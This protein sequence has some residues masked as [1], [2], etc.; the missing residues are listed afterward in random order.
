MALSI[1]AM[2][3]KMHRLR[4]EIEDEVVGQA[5]LDLK[6]IFNSAEEKLAL[7]ESAFKTLLTKGDQLQNIPA[8]VD[9]ASAIVNDLMGEVDEYL[10]GPGQQ[11]ADDIIPKM[12]KAGRDL[13][14][15]NL[16]VKF[17]DSDQLKSTFDLVSMSEKAVLK[18][19]Y[20]DTYKI[21]NVVGDDVTEWFRQTMMDSIFEELPIVNKLDPRAD[22]LMSRL[23]ESG[24]IKPLVIK[25]KSGKMIT[26]SIQQRAE[27]IARVESSKIINRT[28]ETKAAE[29]L[30]DEAVYRNSNPHDSR[31]TPICRR[32]SE[33][34]PMTLVEWS[35]SDLGRPPRLSPFHLCRS[36]LIGGR[37]EWF[38]DVPE[39][40][41]EAQTPLPKTK[42][43]PKAAIASRKALK[44]K[45]A[46]KA[47]AEA[48]KAQE[49]AQALE[50]AKLQEAKISLTAP[51]AIQFAE[52]LKKIENYGAQGRAVRFDGDAVED[53]TFHMYNDYLDPSMSDDLLGPEKIRSFASLKIAEESEQKIVDW[54]KKETRFSWGAGSARPTSKVQDIQVPIRKTLKGG[55]LKASGEY[56]TPGDFYNDPE[57]EGKE[58]EI[59][60]SDGMKIRYRPADLDGVKTP[61]SYRGS[62][63]I[64][65]N[66]PWTQNLADDI[67]KR[68]EDMDIPARL[69]TSADIE[70]A[71]LK[72]MA[73]NATGQEVEMEI[74]DQR[75]LVNVSDT[76]HN[77]LLDKIKGWPVPDQVLELRQF[78]GRR[79]DVDD[80]TTLRAY[81]PEGE[82]DIS[83]SSWVDS[84]GIETAG[85]RHQYRFDIDDNDIPK[86]FNLYHSVA[87]LKES[88][89]KEIIDFFQKG[90]LENSARV[91][92][93]R[94]KIRR[95]IKRS[96]AES[97]AED[98]AGWG[99]SYAYLRSRPSIAPTWGGLY[100]KRRNYRR[101]DARHFK[102]DK[103]GAVP[104][105]EKRL[106]LDDKALMDYS[107]HPENELVLK[108][109]LDLLT[110]LRAIVLA[111]EANVAVLVGKFK[112]AH[113]H[114][115]PDGRKIEDVIMAKDKWMT[116][117]DDAD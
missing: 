18:T 58:Y 104:D 74:R 114:F 112:E 107:A 26:R 8:N 41:L 47:A 77:A 15:A 89:D 42:A 29:V 86:G 3:S 6:A 30:G 110:E 66:G 67:F 44:E 53:L 116:L 73:R 111:E 24:R 85:H 95:G 48:K 97:P 81:N 88:S 39:E 2:I 54:I 43:A 57:L 76:E 38:K 7:K 10:I 28:H 36:V 60:F 93:S 56:E 109:G 105:E 59:K 5:A 72:R 45:A 16:N 35:N 37:A 115:L 78:W 49:A 20:N 79:L 61:L 46:A 9:A 75:M 108:N 96:R 62:M 17:L 91:V 80:I 51:D 4:D 92:S 71:Y 101:L 87:N 52:T 90:I 82:T 21:M 19:G 33:R 100:F 40:V 103:W 27:A 106:R 55:K 99:G 11:W 64:E 50:V 70:L 117:A 102:F 1:P 23:I 22:T 14:R 83:F 13:A 69:S 12:H 84:K 65:A 25:S 94:E 63:E 31:T 98:I 68:L 32:A 34:E 113:I